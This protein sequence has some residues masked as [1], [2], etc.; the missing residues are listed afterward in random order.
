MRRAIALVVLVLLPR[1]LVGAADIP[2]PEH[3]RPDFE[4]ADWVNLNGPWNFRFDP[5]G[6]GID[7]RWFDLA[8]SASG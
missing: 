2:L 3:P 7:E 6:L 1:V 4:R 8:P 5:R